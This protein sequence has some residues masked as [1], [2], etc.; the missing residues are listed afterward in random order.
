MALLVNGERGE[1]ALSIAGV[2][3]VIAA[4]IK[5]LAAVSTALECK[6]FTDLYSRLMSVEAAAVLAGIKFLTVRGDADAA[7]QALKLKHF[8][9]VKLAFTA[10]L[11]HH[12]EGDDD[13]PKDDAAAEAAQT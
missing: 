10:A 9:A 12:L 2:D 11:S 8:P 13:D 3:L 6:S 1:V 7:L 5:R 4:E